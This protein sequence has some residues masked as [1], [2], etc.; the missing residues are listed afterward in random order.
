MRRASRGFSMFELVVVLA[1][2]ALVALTGT[3]VIR[4]TV[5]ADHRLSQISD[6]SRE[7]AVA[8]ALLR[9][10][11][12]AAIGIGF[13][14]PA[15]GA[16]PPLRIGA[17][18]FSLSVGGLGTGPD[19]DGLGRVVWRLDRASGTLTRRVW[20]TLAP[21][22]SQAASAE[23][24]LLGGVRSIAVEAFQLPGGW[25]PGFVADPRQPVSLPRALRVRIDHARHERLETVV[26]LR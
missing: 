4:A 13:V 21:A 16:E 22:A 10:D 25:Q 23:V 1:I 8:L 19:Q 24:T 17:D 14:A 18:G 15:G 20:P 5:Q 9:R 26:S 7:L 12:G 11:L 6:T 2:F 3:Q